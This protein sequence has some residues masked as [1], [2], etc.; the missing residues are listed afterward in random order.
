MQAV[1]NCKDATIERDES[2][3]R[4]D[5]TGK[6]MADAKMTKGLEQMADNAPTNKDATELKQ[7]ARNYDRGSNSDKDSIIRAL[8]TILLT[9]KLAGL[10]AVC[11]ISCSIVGV[12]WK[13]VG[14][15]GMPFEGNVINTGDGYVMTYDTNSNGFHD[16]MQSYDASGHAI[17][18]EE[19]LSGPDALITVGTAA[20]TAVACTVM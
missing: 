4:C 17:G 10:A 13:G 9:A 19:S 12:P 3:I 8:S 11:A 15:S 6:G 1:E 2:K 20:L 16:K 7:V 18:G 5:Y 14:A